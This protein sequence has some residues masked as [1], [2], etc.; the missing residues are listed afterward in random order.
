M[1][2]LLFLLAALAAQAA[3]T[4]PKA[5][6]LLSAVHL[7]LVVVVG[8]AKGRPAANAGWFGLLAGLAAD[9][10]R[11]Q[12][13][14]P[15][16][17]AGA[18]AGAVV[19]K[20]TALFELSGPLF[21]VVGTLV[22]SAVVEATTFLVYASLGHPAPHGLVGSAAALAGTSA[23]GLA[24]ALAEWWYQRT[25]SPQARRRRALRRR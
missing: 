25:F 8:R 12:A 5:P 21:W 2:H 13:L 19:A 10:L 11:G 18:L 16:G 1:S 22:A 14:G 7:W 6:W 9:G 3:L 24:T 23:V 17:L 4:A 20:A 15:T